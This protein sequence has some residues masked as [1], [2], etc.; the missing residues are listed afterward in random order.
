MIEYTY[1]YSWVNIDGPTTG[2]Y[3]TGAGYPGTLIF[4]IKWLS[5]VTDIAGRIWQVVCPLLDSILLEP[6]DSMAIQVH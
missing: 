6:M 3:F 4:K 1:K 5:T 2:F